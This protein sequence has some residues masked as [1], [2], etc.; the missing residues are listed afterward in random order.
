MGLSC[1]CGDYYEW[2]YSFSSNLDFS[3][4]TNR[5]YRPRCQSCKRKINLNELCLC[6]DC[7]RD[8]KT[9]IE[10][11]IYGDEVPLADK[12]LC[13]QCGEIFLNLESLGYCLSLGE[14]L[15]ET[16]REYHELTGFK[17]EAYA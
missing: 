9:D 12:Y 2:F 14:D 10:E 7:Y 1:S 11:S 3:N 16:L 17:P 4:I 15:R 5:V 6:F 8:S 13:E